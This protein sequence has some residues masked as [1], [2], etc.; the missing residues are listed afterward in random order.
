VTVAWVRGCE[1]FAVA[2]DSIAAAVPAHVLCV[3]I[4]VAPGVPPSHHPFMLF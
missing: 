1:R 3:D 2:D 4:Y